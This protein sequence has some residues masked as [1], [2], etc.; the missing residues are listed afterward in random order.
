MCRPGDQPPPAGRLSAHTVRL[1]VLDQ[2]EALTL[3]ARVAGPERVAAEPAVAEA[4]VGLCGHLPW[5]SG[6]PGRDS[7]RARTGRSAA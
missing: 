4:L 6:S 7:P 5:P 1:G 3:L 2:A